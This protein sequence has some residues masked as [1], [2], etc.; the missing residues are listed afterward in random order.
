MRAGGAKRYRGGVASR[1]LVGPQPSTVESFMN[2]IIYIVG[3]IV[4]IIAI[5]SFLGLR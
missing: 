3:A 1:A 5:L 2:N 4:I